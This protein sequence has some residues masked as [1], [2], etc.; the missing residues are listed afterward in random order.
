MPKRPPLLFLLV[1]FV[2]IAAGLYLAKSSIENRI[3]RQIIQRLSADSRV[4][5]VVVTDVKSDPRAKKTYTTIKFLEYDSRMKPLAPRYFTFSSD[6]IQFQSLVIRFEDFYVRSAHPLK[7]KSA[8]LFMKAFAL[9]GADTQVFDI[10]KI[11]EV[12]SG[13]RID[14]QASI[15]EKRLWRRFW[16]YALQPKA[17]RRAGIKNAQIEAPGTKFVPGLLYTLKIEHDGGLRI[18]VSEQPAIL[19]QEK[20]K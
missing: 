9:N 4:A 15:F 17:A 3:L 13:Y 6:I 5:E 16:K 11:G 19:K 18:D 2:F 10:N 14:K 1:A 8:Y 7:G 12:P 20:N